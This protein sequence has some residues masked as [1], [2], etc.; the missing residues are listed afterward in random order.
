MLIINYGHLFPSVPSP[1]DDEKVMYKFSKP[2]NNSNIL[3][4]SPTAGMFHITVNQPFLKHITALFGGGR[5][6]QEVTFS[7]PSL[8]SH[9]PFSTPLAFH[10]HICYYCCRLIYL[11]PPFPLP[12]HIPPNFVY[13]NSFYRPINCSKS[14]KAKYPFYLFLFLSKKQNKMQIQALLSLCDKK[15]RLLQNHAL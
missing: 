8:S 3:A 9:E 5:D 4:F 15:I 6:R 12:S 2:I 1:L 13:Q 10:F 14:A 7:S 11:Y